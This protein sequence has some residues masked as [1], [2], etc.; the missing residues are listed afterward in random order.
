MIENRN[1]TI[2]DIAYM[3]GFND[4]NY[5]TK[6]FKKIKGMTHPLIGNNYNLK[7]CKT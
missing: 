6:V 5:F 1:F 7:Y 2:T 3:V 4:V